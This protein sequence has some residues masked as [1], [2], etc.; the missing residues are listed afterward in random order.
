MNRTW[1][2]VVMG[3]ITALIFS[4]FV[5]AYY[6]PSARTFTQDIVDTYVEVFEPI[7]QALFGGYGWSG[8]YLFE[9]FLL[10]ILVMSLVFLI[11]GKFDMFE[12]NTVVRW[13][14]AIIVPLIGIRFIDFEWLTAL[15]LSYQAFAIALT[16]AIPLIVFF[17][18]VHGIGKDYP[19]VRKILWVVFIGVYLGLW[20]TTA[21]S[22][23]SAAYFWTF[24]AALLF[25]LFDSR[26]EQYLFKKAQQ[27]AGRYWK[28]DVIA[29]L[30]HD[31][32]VLNTA[33]MD[34]TEKRKAIERKQKEI[35]RIS[36]M[37][38]Y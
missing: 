37:D 6:F 10:F 15:L 20:S 11:L 21:S 28:Y 9:R 3:F 25:L 22:G 16:T 17:F 31:I 7:L 29:R 1:V 36:K 2:M 24:I 14:I 33:P 26:I 34:L 38:V 13:I 30:R 19:H 18:F 4:S 35:E 5:S 23:A 27:E 12:K 32:D 8:L